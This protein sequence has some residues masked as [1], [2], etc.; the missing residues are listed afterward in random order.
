VTSVYT[1]IE[2][3]A[4]TTAE[5][6]TPTLDTLRARREEILRI[7]ARHGA[8]NV[9]VFGSVARG[10]A[11]AGS[12]VDFLVDLERGR[13]LLDLGGLIADLEQMLGYTVDV[14]DVGGRRTLGTQH[15]KRS[16]V[17]L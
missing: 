12:D 1:V 5:G 16:A 3:T 9:R 7:A 10:K 4:V 11:H 8:R 13:G 2:A 6:A 14:V 17:P 15:I